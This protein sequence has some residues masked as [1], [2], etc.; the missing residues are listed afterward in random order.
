MVLFLWFC[1]ARRSLCLVFAGHLLCWNRDGHIS[2]ISDKTTVLVFQVFAFQTAGH[3]S[4]RLLPFPLLSRVFPALCRGNP[5]GMLPLLLS[6]KVLQ[7]LGCASWDRR[8]E[9]GLRAREKKSGVGKPKDGIDE[10]ENELCFR[11][12]RL[13]FWCTQQNNLR[14]TAANPSG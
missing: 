7:H 9:E 12:H 10:G 13:S 11:V 2:V 1:V 4:H 5:A 14:P 6:S 3:P 8:R